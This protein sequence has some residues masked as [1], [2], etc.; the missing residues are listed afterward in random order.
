MKKIIQKIILSAVLLSFLFH[1]GYSE[2]TTLKVLHYLDR[3]DTVSTENFNQILAGFKKKNPNINLEFDYLVNEPYHNKLQALNV[4]NQLPDLIFLWP[5]KRTGHVTSS[6]KIKD[7]SSRVKPFAKKFSPAAVVDQGANG[8]IYELPEQVTATHVM[9]VNNK[10]LRKLKL[11]FPK[12]FQELIN[13]G[14]SIRKGGYIPI[15]MD[16]KDGWQMQSCLLSALV[17][18]TGGRDWLNRAVKGKAS[19]ADPEFVRALSVIKTLNDNKMFSPGINQAE[20]GRALSDFVNEKAVYFIDGGWRVPNIIGEMDESLH[21]HVSLEVFP[22]LANEQGLS[23]STSVVAGTGFGMNAKLSG[24]KADAAWEW[25]WYYSGPEGGKIKTKQGW[26]PA[27]KLAQPGNANVITKR[28]AKFLGNTPGGYV[29]DAV[30]DAA[31]IGILQPQIQEM[32]FGVLSPQKVAD[33]FQA[34][35][36]AN[37]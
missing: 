2:Q 32:M 9:Y 36:A 6:G 28:R 30:V 34:W 20:Y 18:R 25:I 33:N 11:K 7:I 27:Y 37:R 31:G 10:L 16:N 23:G 24:A 12:T 8:E 29:I 5:G 26:I 35:V 3:A 22:A 1:I 19:F 15:A 17:E 14:D 13:Q 4:A 21:R